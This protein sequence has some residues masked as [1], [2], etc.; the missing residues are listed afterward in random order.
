MSL[1]RNDLLVSYSSLWLIRLVWNMCIVTGTTKL[2]IPITNAILYA[3]LS[4]NNRNI[5][6]AV[7]RAIAII[8]VY[9]DNG[10]LN[11]KSPVV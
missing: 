9:G 1:N 10:V 2:V 4:F 5:K 7:I 11:F 8:P 3:W 6:Q